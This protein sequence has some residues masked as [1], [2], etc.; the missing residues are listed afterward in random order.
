MIKTQMNANP[1]A[2]RAKA[3]SSSR[4]KYSWKAMTALRNAHI[5]FRPWSLVLIRPLVPIPLVTQTQSK[6]L[7]FG[8]P[9]LMREMAFWTHPPNL[10]QGTGLPPPSCCQ[11]QPPGLL[12]LPPGT[13][14][15]PRGCYKLLHKP[16]L[17]QW[18]QQLS[19][20]VQHALVTLG[21]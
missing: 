17:P 21:Q 3:A 14:L 2:N 7:R 11:D 20:V 8:F 16:V 4:T 18:I 12:F 15:N 10:S 19:E 5:H 1:A 9:F 6:F 13:P